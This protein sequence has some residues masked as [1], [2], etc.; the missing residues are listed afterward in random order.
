MDF[1]A[2]SLEKQD[3]EIHPEIHSKIQIG[4]WFRSQNPHCKDLAL[5]D[6]KFTTGSRERKKGSLQKSFHWN[7]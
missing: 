6:S 5:K 2:S 3:D 1:L 7:F 4:I